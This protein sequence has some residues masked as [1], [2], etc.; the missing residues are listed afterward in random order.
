MTTGMT[1]GSFEVDLFTVAVPSH[2]LEFEIN[3]S[4]LLTPV[5]RIGG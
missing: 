3:G 4:E 1:K 2:P 5:L